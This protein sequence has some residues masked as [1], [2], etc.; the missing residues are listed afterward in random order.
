MPDPFGYISS[1]N[2]QICLIDQIHVT[3]GYHGN[4]YEHKIESFIKAL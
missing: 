4:F 3:A 1:F 2:S